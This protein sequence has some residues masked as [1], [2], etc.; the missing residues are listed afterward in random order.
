[1]GG[2]LYNPC[3][4]HVPPLYHPRT[5]HVL[6][7]TKVVVV[8]LPPPMFLGRARVLYS[9]TH[10]PHVDSVVYCTILYNAIQCI[11]SPISLLTPAVPPSMTFEPHSRADTR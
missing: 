2:T 5:T 11:V 4:T 6:Q 9:F 10:I 7:E 1:M 3:I 8:L